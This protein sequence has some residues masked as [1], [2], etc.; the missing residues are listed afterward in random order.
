MVRDTDSGAGVRSSCSG[1]ATAF[2]ALDRRR[3]SQL[4]EAVGKRS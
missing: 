1:D 4:G 2:N 3:R